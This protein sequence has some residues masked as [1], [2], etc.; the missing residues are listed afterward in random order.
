MSCAV[1]LS[2]RTEPEL[3]NMEHLSQYD[4]GML[5][6]NGDDIPRCIVQDAGTGAFVCADNLGYDL[7]FSYVSRWNVVGNLSR[8]DDHLIWKCRVARWQNMSK[9]DQHIRVASA[10]RK[11]RGFCCV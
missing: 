2:I 6:E 5:I 1:T 8:S 11:Q 10:A 7:H 9:Q 4:Q 3:S